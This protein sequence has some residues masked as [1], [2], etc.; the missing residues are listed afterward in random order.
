MGEEVGEVVFVRRASGLVREVGPF[1]AL[2][3]VLCHVIGG[4]INKFSVTASV[5]YP[6]A[7][8]PVAF[9]VAGIPTILLGIVIA[10][11]AIAMPRAGGDYIYITRVLDPTIG[12]LAS[13][14][15]WYTEAVSYGIIAY[16]DV[17][18]WG[19]SLWIAGVALKNPALISTGLVW[20]NE[21]WAKAVGG[22]VLVTIF[23][24]IGLLGLRLYATIMNILLII[25]AIGSLF[26]I[27]AFASGMGAAQAMWEEVFGAGTWD[28]VFRI[29]RNYGWSEKVYGMG[30]SWTATMQAT[31][32]ATWAY[33]GFTATAFV[34]SEVREPSKSFMVGI[35]LGSTIIAAYYIFISWAVYAAYGNF[36]SAYTYLTSQSSPLYSDPAKWAAAQADLKAALGMDPPVSILPLYAAI[37]FHRMPWAAFVCAITGA[38]WL[39]NDIPAFLLVC[40]RTV[41]AW[42][43][44]RF[45]PEFF[46]AV[47]RYHSPWVAVIFTSIVGYISVL[48]SYWNIE[49]LLVDTTVL[50]IF[51]YLF[52]AL[53]GMMFPFRRPDIYEKGLKLEIAGLPLI[54]ILGW[55]A[56][57]WWTYIFWFTST[58]LEA[59]GILVYMIWEGLGMLIFAGY[60][61]YNIRRGIDVS[62]IYREI[63]PA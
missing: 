1:T 63:P 52:V 31:V 41:F 42:A 62:T 9:I 37:L 16:A 36:V 26:M 53:T 43:F 44:D 2:S 5:A 47:N 20:M 57:T 55:I 19:L 10:L 32:P 56:F 12:F 49:A 14:A 11:M 13:W 61:I 45:F 58:T 15:F 35:A 8:V 48:G 7:N 4:G 3:I 23:L 21:A 17:E 6:G 50:A 24:I 28:A 54:T 22:A 38:M 27:A 51:R 30:A 34:G 40:S 39:M 25:P 46:A 60:Y 29:A 18:F 33:I 59:V